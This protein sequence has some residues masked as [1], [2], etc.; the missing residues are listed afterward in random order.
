VLVHSKAHGTTVTA[1][2]T[3]VAP[4]GGNYTIGTTYPAISGDSGSL[5]TTPEGTFVGFVSALTDSG[6]LISVPPVPAAPVSLPAPVAIPPPVLP[7]V[8]VEAEAFAR[9]ILEG[10]R[11]AVAL[12]Q[13][14][15]G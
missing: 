11:Q 15:I 4:Y 9:G 8:G 5:V 3:A 14:T 1:T 2:V 6:S 13:A 12:V 10:K 7:V